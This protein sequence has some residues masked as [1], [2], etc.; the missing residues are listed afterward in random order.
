MTPFPAFGWLALAELAVGAVLLGRLVFDLGRL[1]PAIAISVGVFYA[2]FLVVTSANVLALLRRSETGA[3]LGRPARMALA[4][5]VPVSLLGSTLDCMGLDFDGCTPACGFLTHAVAPAIAVLVVVFA[6]TEARAFALLA[7]LGALALV[8][9][10]C[11]CRNPVNRFWIGLLGRSPACYASAFAVFLV[12]TT[13]LLGR[14]LSRPAVLL[15]WGVVL[16]QLA[17]WIGHH[18]FHVPW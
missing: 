13:A 16:A 5:A 7:A 3:P 2:G 4:L 12:A 10:N 14:R 8:Y 6:W 1:N 15:A 18:Y 9:P 11:Q 17:F